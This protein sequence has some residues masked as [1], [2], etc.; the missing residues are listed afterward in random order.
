MCSMP[1]KK[2]EIRIASG[3]LVSEIQKVW[4]EQAGEP[5]SEESE[6]VMHRAHDFLAAN[7]DSDLRAILGGKGVSDYLGAKWV[8]RYP[9][10]RPFITALEKSK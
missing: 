5:S 8:S 2:A 4:H 9:H 10:L 1:T 7:S 6:E 3:K